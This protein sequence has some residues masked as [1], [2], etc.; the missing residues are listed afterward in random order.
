MPRLTM[1]QSATRYYGKNWLGLSDREAYVV[2]G[3]QFTP[4]LT[5]FPALALFLGM[6]MLTWFRESR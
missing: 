6:I 2:E 3:V 5:G 4:L 1:L